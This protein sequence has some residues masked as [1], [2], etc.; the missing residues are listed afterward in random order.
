MS[1]FVIADITNPSCSPLELQATV[2]IFNIPFA[3][4]IRKGEK[5]FSMFKDLQSSFGGSEAQRMLDLLTYSSPEVLVKVLEK[6]I[7][8]PALERSKRLSEKKQAALRT[9][10][11]EDYL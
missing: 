11:A 2:P 7:V 8:T 1:F 6:A 9:R 5:P 4:I 10:D 3:P